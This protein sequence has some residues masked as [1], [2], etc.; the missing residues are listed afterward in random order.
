LERLPL[1]PNF[2]LDRRRLRRGR[3]EDAHAAA[4]SHRETRTAL[5]RELAAIWSEVLN[6]PHIDTDADFFDL[7]GHSLIASS[8]ISRIEQRLG[9]EL[10]LRQFF[11]A[12][13]IHQLACVV[14]SLVGG[15]RREMTPMRSLPRRHAARCTEP[16]ADE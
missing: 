4:A 12:P 14:A 8:V 7:G 15:E 16:I 2:K 6:V 13:T 9:I 3:E 5:E 1:T 10:Q 11:D